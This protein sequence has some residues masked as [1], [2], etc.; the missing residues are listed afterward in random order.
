MTQTALWAVHQ[1]LYERL[2]AD[3]PLNA[4]V[5]GVFDAVEEDVT[6]P[7]VTLGAPTTINLTTRTTFSE[8]ISITL[9][10]WSIKPGKKESYDLLNAIHQAIGKGL[11]VDGPFRLLAAT[12]PTM[13]VIDDLDPQ[14]KHG[15]ARFTFT[16]Q[17]T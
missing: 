7:Y 12:R 5:T 13:E 9:H 8:E 2:T 10:T 15:L 17:N 4:L 16:I 14:I 3:V 11:S 1:A 6:F